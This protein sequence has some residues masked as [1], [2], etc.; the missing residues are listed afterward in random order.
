M[1][2]RIVPIGLGEWNYLGGG[3]AK[4]KT[5]KGKAKDKGIEG[6]GKGAMMAFAS[7]STAFGSSP[8]MAHIPNMSVGIVVGMA[9]QKLRKLTVR[10]RRRTLLGGRCRV[11]RERPR[12]NQ[13]VVAGPKRAAI[14]R[15]KVLTV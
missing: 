9:A 11:N 10:G 13:R 12:Q 8:R 15:A 14:R 5:K 6:N 7:A 3:K 1:S 2:T 4:D